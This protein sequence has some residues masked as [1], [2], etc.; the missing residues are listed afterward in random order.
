MRPQLMIL[1][2]WCWL[3]NKGLVASWNGAGWLIPKDFRSRKLGKVNAQAPRD[4][5][6]PMRGSR[7]PQREVAEV[8]T[9]RKVDVIG[10]ID[11]E[12][13]CEEGWGYLHEVIEFPLVLVDCKQGQVLG[14]FQSFVRPVENATL[15]DFCTQLTG[16]AQETVDSAPDLPA[17]LDLVDD[18][19]RSRN[20]VGDN[21]NVSFSLATDGWSVHNFN[22]KKS[23]LPKRRDLHHFLD[24]ECERKGIE[25]PPGGYLDEWVDLTKAFDERR[26]KHK[27]KRKPTYARRTTMSKMLR[28]YGMLFQGRKHSGIDDARNLARLAAALLKEG[29]VL[30]VNDC[31]ADN[32]PGP[33]RN[34]QTVVASSTV[35]PSQT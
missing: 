11:F 13:T 35:A 22:S 14:E 26:S 4:M 25:K 29:V 23:A 18:F 2:I 15:S 20:L 21:A 6:R 12:C 7:R 27:R 10:V 17:V 8:D 32:R 1:T 31:T 16:I 33:L 9:R 28:Y 19:L 5:R 24:T 30:R 3:L 34:R